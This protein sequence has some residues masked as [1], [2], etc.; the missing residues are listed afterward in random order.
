MQKD[1]DLIQQAWVDENECNEI[2][3]IPYLSKN[4]R[5]KIYRIGR[6]VAYNTRP[7]HQEGCWPI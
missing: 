4:Q 1:I 2:S 3:F 5:K 6:I 7:I